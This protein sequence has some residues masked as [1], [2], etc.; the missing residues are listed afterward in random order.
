MLSSPVIL[1]SPPTSNFQPSKKSGWLIFS[2]VFIIHIRE[3]KQPVETTHS[4]V[5]VLM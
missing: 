5:T 3:E 2:L 1:L 4:C